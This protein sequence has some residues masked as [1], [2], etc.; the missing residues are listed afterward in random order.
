M[1]LC[2]ELED[3]ANYLGSQLLTRADWHQSVILAAFP[4]PEP[5]GNDV[6]ATPC[7][8]LHA[9]Q[10]FTPRATLPHPVLLACDGDAINCETSSHCTVELDDVNVLLNVPYPSY[11]ALPSLVPEEHCVTMLSLPQHCRVH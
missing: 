6:E 5:I 8:L 7:S 9:P 4:D 2:P 10:S 1:A 3:D 11:E